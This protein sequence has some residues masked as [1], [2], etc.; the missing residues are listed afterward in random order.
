MEVVERIRKQ[1]PE[2][3]SL[4]YIQSWETTDNTILNSILIAFIVR[5]SFLRKK[6]LQEYCYAIII[7]GDFLEIADIKL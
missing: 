6:V 3:N 5:N 7:Q 2:D 1:P 4:N